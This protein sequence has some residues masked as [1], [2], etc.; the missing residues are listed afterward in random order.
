[1][2]SISKRFPALILSF[3]V[4]TGLVTAQQRSNLSSQVN[5]QKLT[6]NGTPASRGFVCPGTNNVYLGLPYTDTSTTPNTLYMC[7]LDGWVV[8]VDGMDAPQSGASSDGVA[9]P[10]DHRNIPANASVTMQTPGGIR[11]ASQY[12]NRT[13]NGI[14]SAAAGADNQTV[15]A[16]ASYPPTEVPTPYSFSA[17]PFHYRDMRNGVQVDYFHN[18]T[19]GSPLLNMNVYPASVSGGQHY[20]CLFDKPPTTW[21]GHNILG[22]CAHTTQID[23]MP[24]WSIGNPSGFDSGAGSGWSTFIPTELVH[25]TRTSGITE[26]LAIVQQ[27]YSTG[28]NAPLYVYTNGEGG[29]VSASDEGTEGIASNVTEDSSEFTST[30]SSG[31]TSG[32]IS[33]KTPA[34]NGAQGQGRYLYDSTQRPATG[35]VTSIA[36][37]LG[38]GSALT[39]D[40]AVS[41]S[42]AWGTLAAAVN[43]P[44]QPQPPFTTTETFNVNVARGAF[45][46]TH[47]ACFAGNFH[48]Q[49]IPIAAGTPSGGVQSVTFSLRRPHASGTYIFQGGACGSGIEFPAFTHNGLHYLFDVVGSTDAH[50]LQTVAFAYGKSNARLN[51]LVPV[52]QTMTFSNSM[53]SSGSTVSFNLT[54][55]TLHRPDNHAGEALAISGASDPALNTICTNMQWT[56]QTAGTCTVSSLSGT[57]KTTTS[58]AATLATST[59]AQNTYN[60]Y[61]IA[62][63]LDV[64]NE[65]LSPPQ[66]DGTL[67]LEPNRIAFATGDAVRETHH[68]SGNFVPGVF[69][70]DVKN[71]Y[72]TLMKGLNV[73]VQGYG[74]QGGGGSATTNS[75]VSLFNL[76]PDNYYINSGGALTPPNAINVSGAYSLGINFGQGPRSDEP[77]INVQSDSQPENPNY[78]Y[79]PMALNGKSG[80]VFQMNYQPNSGHFAINSLGS[81]GTLQ[82][83]GQAGI[84]FAGAPIISAIDAGT[85]A[86]TGG[87]MNLAS[88]SFHAQVKA[89]ARIAATYAET[90]PATG[91]SGQLVDIANGATTAAGHV[92]MFSNT[93]ARLQD[94]GKALPLAASLSTTAATTDNVTV[95][96]M[97][98]SGHCSLTPTNATAAM[99]LSKTYISAKSTDQIIVMH[100]AIAS[101]TYDVL[102]TAY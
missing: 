41:V 100:P 49:A 96:G 35:H 16:D 60:L 52:T 70:N 38:S 88:G 22:G 13:N 92:A 9:G 14:S 94:S 27:K 32:S 19:F 46:T 56:S 83:Y 53:S 74:A 99:N 5:W 28:D 26:T 42:N 64:Q 95:T 67:A 51:Y 81:T 76:N 25:Y 44:V 75:L 31:C 77:L 15:V 45:D 73:S 101:L 79:Y 23:N 69:R 40:S 4:L 6:G 65:A 29:T 50:T 59:E 1:M 93:T 102:C 55:T 71:P 82:L 7:G 57:H 39:L 91:S 21:T 62:E 89:P 47:L 18:P 78:N 97:T 90:L 12:G 98:A 80:L 3:I 63:V 58:P 43:T 84:T 68:Y 48:E 37:G 30:C 85:N 66:V 17:S 86:I 33:I 87:Q 61:P 34:S 2:R 24:G 54:A 72:L 20:D 10:S 36:N 11:Y 8:R